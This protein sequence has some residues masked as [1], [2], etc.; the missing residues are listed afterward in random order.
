MTSGVGWGMGRWWTMEPWWRPWNR[1][2]S[3]WARFALVMATF[4]FLFAPVC[5]VVGVLVGHSFGDAYASS[6]P[7]SLLFVAFGVMDPDRP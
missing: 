7:L 2:R 1:V 6:L 3:R 4:F 5:A